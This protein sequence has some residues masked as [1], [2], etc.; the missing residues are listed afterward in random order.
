MANLLEVYDN[1]MKTA[2]EAEAEKQAEDR[3][4]AVDQKK[5]KF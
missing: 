1:M 4:V 5:S 3:A 2:G